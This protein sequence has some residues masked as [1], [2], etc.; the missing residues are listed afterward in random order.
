M[1]K[2]KQREKTGSFTKH[3]GM[4]EADVVAINP[5]A[6]WLA[7]NGI[8]VKEDS[9]TTEYFGEREGNL[10]VRISVWL[11][12]KDGELYNTNFF[13]ENKDKINQKG[14]KIQYVNTACVTSWCPLGTDGKG[15]E[16]LLHEW[17]TGRDFK[18]AI[19]GEEELYNFLRNWFNFDWRDAENAVELDRKKLFKGN[20]RE[21]SEWIGKPETQTVCCSVEVKTVEKDGEVTEY[22]NVNNRFFLP[23]WCMKFFRT[24]KFDEGA[25]EQLRKKERKNLKNFEK[26]VVDITDPE[27][28]S[29]NFYS[30]APLHEYTA[31]ENMASS[32]KVISSD[33]SDY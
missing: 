15:A 10:T 3:V 26:F 8:E 33:S 32:E 31:G 30:L 5:T 27:Y 19:Q 2:G 28:G 11:R 18:V 12:T 14:D 22:Q 25:I 7:E 24:K 17:F 9:K 16:D 23:G 13:L 20:V 4:M 29:R 6:E 21:I 1:I